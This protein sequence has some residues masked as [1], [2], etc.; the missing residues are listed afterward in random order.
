MTPHRAIAAGIALI[1]ADRQRDG[2]VGT[3]PVGDN[4]MLQVLSAYHVGLRLRRGRKRRAQA[5]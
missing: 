2:A 3:L 1:P 5:S 4:V